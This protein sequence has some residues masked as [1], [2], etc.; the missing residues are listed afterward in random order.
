MSDGAAE[1]SRTWWDWVLGGLLLVGG[2]VV[3]GHA[4]VA[5]AVSVIF[6]GWLVF[7][8]GLMV[9]VMSLFRIGKDGFWIGLLEGGLLAV[10]GFV[11]LRN[12]EAA[13]LTLT[14]IAGALFLSTGI[15]R[16]AA[17]VQVEDGRGALIFSGAVSSLLGLLV[18]FNLV[19]ATFTL[20][21]ILLGVQMLTEG[22]AVLI[23][24]RQALSAGRAGVGQPA[25]G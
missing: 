7:A 23:S 18:I 24:G 3:I 8:A 19:T 16:L 14:L 1:E 10:L 25:V 4:V 11:F 6:L 15:A 22:L 2:L 17:A 20:L 13:A 5:T 21:G 12:P 9:L